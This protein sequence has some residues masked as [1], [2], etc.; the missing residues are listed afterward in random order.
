MTEHSV[1]LG[2]QGGSRVRQ[3]SLSL[4]AVKQPH[5]ELILELTYLSRD[6]GLGDVQSLRRPA[7]MQLLGDGDEISEMTKL[8]GLLRPSRFAQRSASSVD[9]RGGDGGPRSTPPRRPD[10]ATRGVAL[11]AL[12]GWSAAA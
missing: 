8:H 4:R 3:G 10:R 9:R 6:R 1:C 11:L 12:R 2:E 5:P 7:E